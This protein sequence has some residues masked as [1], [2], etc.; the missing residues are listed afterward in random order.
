[1]TFTVGWGQ[2][3]IGLVVLVA[4]LA[5]AALMRFDLP[6]GFH[7]KT[8]TGRITNFRRN[9]AQR[10]CTGVPKWIEQT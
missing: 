7:H 9:R 8:K 2:R 4:V 1:M 10:K 3:A 6:L 5:I